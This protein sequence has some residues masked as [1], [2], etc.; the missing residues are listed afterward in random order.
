MT[1]KQQIKK[2]DEEASESPNDGARQNSTAD[3]L[4]LNN[5]HDRRVS[6]QEKNNLFPSSEVSM[7]AFV[8]LRFFIL[9]MTRC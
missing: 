3:L 9:M 4:R 8:L 2:D 6:D 1:D 7:S 5:N